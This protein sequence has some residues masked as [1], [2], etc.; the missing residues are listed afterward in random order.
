MACTSGPAYSECDIPEFIFS[1]YIFTYV[2]F[3]KKCSL[4]LDLQI[5]SWKAHLLALKISKF[6]TRTSNFNDELLLIALLRLS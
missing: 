5:H 3:P 1:E 2:I 6:L 4:N